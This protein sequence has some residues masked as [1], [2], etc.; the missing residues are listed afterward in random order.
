[1]PDDVLQIQRNVVELSDEGGDGDGGAVNLIV[2]SGG[3]GFAVKDVTPEV[4]GSVESWCD[5]GM[6]LCGDGLL[7]VLDVLW[8]IQ[9]PHS[10]LL[11][12]VHFNSYI[13]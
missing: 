3:T 2:T 12:I 6:E 1:M 5:H 7:L 10:I 8:D 4:S 13:T 9:S 11:S